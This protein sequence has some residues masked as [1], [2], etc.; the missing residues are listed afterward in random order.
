MYLARVPRGQLDANPVYRTAAG[1]SPDA[2]AAVPISERYWFENT[3]QP[4]YL[5]GRWVSV[6]KVDGFYGEEVVVEIASDPWGP[7]TS[8]AT[9]P[10]VPRFGT[11]R[12]NSYQPVLVPWLD[13]DR[14]LQIVISENARYWDEAVADPGMYRPSVVTIPWPF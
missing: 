10:H 2:A 7:W 13:P 5:G 8:A 4:R 6:T 11:E 14:N 12:G 1:W 9:Y 3:M